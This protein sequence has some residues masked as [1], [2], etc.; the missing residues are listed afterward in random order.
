[1][2]TGTIVKIGNFTRLEADACTLR[3]IQTQAEATQWPVESGA[4]ISDHVILQPVRMSLE[5]LFSPDPLRQV[6]GT[7][8]GP[9]RP[10]RAYQ[11]LREAA[12]A[13]YNIEVITPQDRLTE[14]VLTR[15]SSPQSVGDGTTRRVVVEVQQVRRVSA[16]ESDLPQKIARLKHAG[17][18]SKGSLAASLA[19]QAAILAAQYKLDPVVTSL[20]VTSS[21]ATRVQGALANATQ[22]EV[23]RILGVPTSLVTIGS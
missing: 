2:A 23:S 13:R 3:E 15:V 14:L 10:Q 5:L 18:S 19:T 11:L 17:K 7:P 20:T 6:E 22:A 16:Q 8:P 1:M 12:V 21:I 9:Q 4:V